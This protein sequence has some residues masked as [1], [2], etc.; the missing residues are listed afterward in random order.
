MVKFVQGDIFTSG[1]DALVNA[2]NTKG[3]MG[4]GIALEFKKR[5][6]QNFDAYQAACESGFSVGELLFFEESG[7]WIINFPTKADYRALSKIE[8]IEQGLQALAEQLPRY[9][10]KSVAL[11]ALGCGLGGLRWCDVR[12]LME[13][14]LGNVE[15]M[16]I[17]VFEPRP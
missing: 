4:A 7:Y 6:P 8:Y 11:P 3:V 16:E 1:A 15:N 12:P 10:F 5:F 2:V 17:S 14:Y 9:G 13:T